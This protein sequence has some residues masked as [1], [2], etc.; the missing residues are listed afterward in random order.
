MRGRAIAFWY[1]LLDPDEARSHVPR[2]CAMERDPIV[3]ARFW[4]LRH[5]AGSGLLAPEQWQAFREAVVAFPVSCARV[6]GDFTTHMF[7]DDSTYN[8]FGREVMGWP[9]RSGEIDV[10]APAKPA[11]GS[12]VHAQLNYRGRVAMRAAVTLGQ[13]REASTFPTALPH[14]IGWKLIPA[15]DGTTMVVDEI[16]DTGPS[17][18]KWGSI[19]DAAGSLEFPEGTSLELAGLRPR[20]IVAVQYW[21]GISLLIGPGRVLVNHLAGD[22]GAPQA[23]ERTRA[24]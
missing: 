5:D 7:G 24:S 17:E 13:E 21:T 12:K 11:P 6:E 20:E 15:V 8:A 22:T 14:W 3:R 9:L 4:D 2:D 19:W 10:Q 1:R 23:A 18:L 16:T